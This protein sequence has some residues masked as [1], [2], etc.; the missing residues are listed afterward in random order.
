[1]SWDYLPGDTAQAVA[2]RVDTCRNLGLVLDRFNPW[3]RDGHQ[4]DLQYGHGRYTTDRQRWLEDQVGNRFD[5]QLLRAHHARWLVGVRAHGANPF[6]LRTQTYL[7]VGLGR[8]HVLE[9][10]ITL[11]PIYGYPI[12]PGSTLKGMTRTFFLYSLAFDLGVPALP[13]EM[14]WDYTREQKATPLNQLDLLLEQLPDGGEE[15]D[16]KLVHTFTALQHDPA[17]SDDAA[18]KGLDLEAFGAHGAVK[19]FRAIF[20]HLNEAGWVVFFDAVPAGDLAIAL[21]IMNPH[22][23]QYYRGNGAPHDADNPTP[24][25]FLTVDSGVSF[26]FAVAPRQVAKESQNQATEIAK[27]AMTQALGSMGV[28][29]KTASGYGR[30]RKSKPVIPQEGPEEPPIPSPSPRHRKPSRPEPDRGEE[31]SSGPDQI[32]QRAADFMEF[33]RQRSGDDDV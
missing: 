13:L 25:Q 28:G 29:A 31:R 9:T 33:L 3:G 14:Y 24:I 27:E 18:L 32:S 4:W 21:D 6:R 17:L 26:G 10:A 22:Y 12:I 15:V 11:H 23:P 16:N 30:F 2:R 1:M 5:A 20:G 19:T 8:Q 7:L